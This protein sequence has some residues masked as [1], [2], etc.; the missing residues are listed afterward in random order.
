MFPINRAVLGCTK[1]YTDRNSTFSSQ[2]WSPWGLLPLLGTL[3]PG[4]DPTAAGIIRTVC[5]FQTAMRD[6]DTFWNRCHRVHMSALSHPPLQVE[7]KSEEA[8][9]LSLGQFSHYPL[10]STSRNTTQH[11]CVVASGKDDKGEAFRTC[12]VDK[13]GTSHHSPNTHRTQT[14]GWAPASA[15]EHTWDLLISGTATGLTI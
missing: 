15:D 6:T 11:S 7:G 9:R 2:S 14:Q 5:A 8:N 12:S 4:L 1:S 13:E 3:T 10:T